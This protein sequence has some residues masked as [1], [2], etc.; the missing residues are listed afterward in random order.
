MGFESGFD[1]AESGC[2]RHGGGIDGPLP[3]FSLM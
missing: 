2:T 1:F 3:T